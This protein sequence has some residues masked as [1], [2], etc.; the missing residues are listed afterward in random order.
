MFQKPLWPIVVLLVVS[1]GC[2]FS[3]SST[4]DATADPFSGRRAGQERD[5]N[6]VQMKL[7]WCPPGSFTMGS[8]AD[9]EG[10]GEGEDQIDV[11]LTRGF[12][13]GKYEVTQQQWRTTL[14]TEPWRNNDNV[15]EGAEFPATWINR[16][17]ARLFC[18]AL[19]SQEQAAGRLPDH[20]EYRLPTEAQWEYAARAG[21]KTRF[22]G[23]ASDKRL[24]D[25]AWISASARGKGEQYAHAIGLKEANAWG[26]HDVHG[27]VLEWCRD[28]YSPRRAGGDDPEGVD[29]LSVQGVA[30]GGDWNRGADAARLARREPLLYSRRNGT[31]GLRVVLVRRSEASNAVSAPE[32]AIAV[33]PFE[34]AGPSVET[35]RLGKALGEMLAADLAEIESLHVLERNNVDALIEERSLAES[36]VTD[37]D[38]KPRSESKV[39]QYLLTGS[40]RAEDGKLAMK[41]R[42]T[43]PGFAKPQGEWTLEGT[44]DDLLPLERRL[45]NEVA[46]SLGVAAGKKRAAPGTRNG[47]APTLAILPLV[48][49]S[50]DAKLDD[51]G[52]GLADVLQASL[53]AFPAVRLVDRKELDRVL[54][55]QRLSASGLVDPKSAVAVGKLLQ[56]ERLLLG[57]FLELGGYVCLHARL[58][59]AGTGAVLSSYKSTGRRDHMSEVIE[60]LT[61]KTVSD[62]A[63]GVSPAIQTAVEKKSQAG[64]L[65]GLIH[66]TNMYR[67]A[68]QGKFAEAAEVCQRVIL[69]EPGNIFFY[70][71]RCHF[72]RSIARYEEILRMAELARARPEFA[73]APKFDSSNTLGF[74]LTALSKLLRYDE[75][76]RAARRYAEMFPDPDDQDFA[77][78]W[79]VSALYSLGRGAEVE[80]FLKKAAETETDRDHD[81]QNYSLRRLFAHYRSPAHYTTSKLGSNYDPEFSKAHC[82]NAIAIFDRALKSVRGKRDEHTKEWGK[83]LIPEIANLFFVGKGMVSA[84]YFT[85]E[86]QV[87]VLRRGIEAFHDEPAIVAAGRFQLARILEESRKWDAALEAYRDVWRDSQGVEFSL[88]PSDWDLYVSEWDGRIKQPTT[89]I[90]RKI[91]AGYRVAKILDEPLGRKDTARGAYRELVREAGLAH[92]AGADAI[93]DMN[94]LGIEPEFP[95]K[96]V[97]LWGGDTSA[98]LS[99]RKFLEPAGYQVHTLREL[100]VN[101]PQLAPYALVILIRSG[102]LVFTPREAFALRSYVAAGGALLAVVSTGWEPAPP[103]IHNPL[104]SF[105][106]MECRDDPAIVAPATRI[107]AH[108]ITAGITDVTARNAVHIE[109]PS[110]ARLMESDDKTILAAADYR[111]GRIAVA[112]F[113]QWYLPDTSILPPDWRELAP[114][115]RRENLHLSP[116]EF[117]SRLETPLLRNVITWL[118][119]RSDRGTAHDDWRTIWR[120]AQMTAWKAQAQVEPPARRLIPWNEMGPVFERLISAA[121]DDVAREESLWLAGEAFQQMGFLSV[122]KTGTEPRPVLSYPAYGYNPQSDPLLGE[123]R[124]FRE[125]IQQFP[126]SP[127]RP[128]A[129]WRLAECT[130]RNGQARAATQIFTDPSAGR[131]LLREYRQIQAP[132][133][134]YARTWT[135]LRLGAIQY[136]LGEFGKAALY[137]Q[138]IAEA[139]PTGPEKLLALLNL[140]LCYERMDQTAEALRAYEA[141]AALPVIQW[142]PGVDWS[143]CWGPIHSDINAPPGSTMGGNGRQLAN[144]GKT[145]LRQK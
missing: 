137:F 131:R 69:I 80:D 68:R 38:G 28:W 11:T 86:Q 26:L 41:G 45:V 7:V 108:P 139:V 141:A 29:G 48:N 103:G 31:I 27:N 128:Y 65:E 92:F 49:H 132:D 13:I 109:A 22:Q 73:A 24:T 117:G 34:N 36:N 19:T 82:R 119:G 25:S 127:L 6:A 99:W 43:K 59:D 78:S 116:V 140:G 79:I 37:S 112:S 81:W 129:E 104:L 96:C 125:L 21:T 35:G 52:S 98:L 54:A 93:V 66:Q 121:P 134:S 3:E 102:N 8:P 74:E 77:N 136:A 18:E 100:R 83:L 91:E 88:L 56:A 1:P 97:L 111:F 145:R 39:A 101:P 120:E 33:V 89:W 57:S 118:T 51:Y 67:L 133:R 107:V 64:T 42:L 62:L 16:D 30:R 12:W 53:G 4:G 5:D 138:E 71:E 2:G 114:G 113:G 14:R 23:G 55:E 87:E 15:R 17:D 115:G 95:D 94:R 105:F 60:D 50:P 76:L 63:I 9:E 124:Y 123:P 142:R 61:L 122:G 20:W 40:F 72:L 32:L 44:L 58:I 47:P 135:N 46:A 75:L 130:R 10:R 143:M 90:D 110:G 126:D 84:P 70:R 144:D 85:A 106:G